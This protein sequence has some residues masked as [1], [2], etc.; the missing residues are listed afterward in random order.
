MIIKPKVKIHTGVTLKANDEVGFTKPLFD[1]IAWY[2][3]D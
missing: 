3:A 1:P 2:T